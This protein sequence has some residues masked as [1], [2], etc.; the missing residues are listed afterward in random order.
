MPA[1]FVHGV[2][3]TYHV[4]DGVRVHLTRED[5]VALA[6]PGFGTPTPD[7]FTATKEAYVAW[8]IEQVEAQ[9]EPVDLVGHDWGC[10]FTARVASLRPDL[11]RTWVGGC[12]PLVPDFEWAEW[13]TAWQTPI[14]GERWMADLDQRWLSGQLEANGVPAGVARASV[15]RIDATMKRA[16]LGLYRSAVEV[17]AEWEPG[18]RGVSAPSL[19]FWGANDRDVQHADRLAAA[20]GA[21]PVAKFDAGHWPQLQHPEEVARLVSEHWSS[22]GA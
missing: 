7:G 6:L 18:L 12:G 17:G 15:D 10:M 16:I 21:G 5:V 1:V 8:I 11:V 4:W 14:V 9:G 22:A 19:I 2:P 3:D 20:V 13:P